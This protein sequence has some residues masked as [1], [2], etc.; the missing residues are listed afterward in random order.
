MTYNKKFNV[1]LADT[2]ATGF[3]YYARYL[4]WMEACRIDLLNQTGTSLSDLI[5]Q[6]ISAV[7]RN[8]LCNYEAPI[9]MGD[10]VEVLTSVSKMGKTNVIIAYEFINLTTGKKAGSG[11]VS[12]VFIDQNSHRPARIPQNIADCF[13][14]YMNAA[15]EAIV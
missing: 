2:D 9:K 13:G 1:Y 4:E 10:E 15:I 7:V 14:K 5:N 3:V 8:V 12:I 11:E 6:G